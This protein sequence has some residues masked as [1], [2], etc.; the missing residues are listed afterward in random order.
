MK[1]VRQLTSKE[2]IFVGVETPNIYQH[3]GGLLI[4]DASDHPGWG[5]ET[6]RKYAERQLGEIPQFRWR[7]DQVAFGLDMPYWVEDENFN[8]ERHLRRVAVPSP[9]DDAALAE[10]VGYLY[11]K[12]MD[13]GQA[14]WEAWFIEGLEGGRFALFF[15]VHHCLM[16]GQGAAKLIDYMFED[17]PDDKP[18]PLP[19]VLADAR[20]GEPPGTWHKSIT[21]A[22][23]LAGLPARVSLE[24]NSMLLQTLRKRLR[25]S[26][27]NKKPK[28]PVPKVAFNTDVGADRSFIFTSLSMADIKAVKNHYDV[29]V[30]DVVLA[31][32]GGSLRD[33]LS[34]H[35]ELPEEALRS[36]IA[37][38][39]RDEDDDEFS[40]KVTTAAVTLAT[41]LEDPEER[42]KAIAAETGAAKDEAHRKSH[43]GSMEVH[44][45]LPPIVNTALPYLVPAD[46]IAAMAGANLL[47]SNVRSSSKHLYT[48]GARVEAIYPM[49]IVGPAL[50]INVTCIGYADNIDFGITLAPELFPDSWDIIDGLNKYLGEYRSLVRKKSQR[51]KSPAKKTS[52]RA[53]KPVSVAAKSRA[54]QAKPKTRAAK[55]HAPGSRKKSS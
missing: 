53:K 26:R 38:S 27:V 55:K 17:G 41:D 36:F 43:R 5:F 20:A 49:S 11:S 51:R 30:N 22:R 8:I 32:V 9:G 31:L 33:Y 2:V 7:L 40:N 18:K 23:R 46:K 25:K 12:H 29:S 15:K 54:A 50:S 45:L 14:L 10:L 42:L 21:A 48:A 13:R 52:S 39:L 47:V 3:T 37:V 19:A 34:Q 35:H 6:Y 4:L 28:P 44:Q 24:A 1:N 16:D